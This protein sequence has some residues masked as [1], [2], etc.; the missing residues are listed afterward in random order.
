[1]GATASWLTH[2]LNTRLR[3]VSSM[4]RLGPRLDREIRGWL[5]STLF[6]ATSLL[7]GCGMGAAKTPIQWQEGAP[8]TTKMVD[9]VFASNLAEFEAT[10]SDEEAILFG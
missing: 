10:S 9:K 4:N 2:T 1:M 5:L 8:P 7:T 3:R 6:L